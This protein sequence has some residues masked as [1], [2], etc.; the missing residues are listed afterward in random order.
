M[1]EELIHSF[2]NK[3]LNCCYVPDTVRYKQTVGYKD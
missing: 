3:Y 2:S 1:A